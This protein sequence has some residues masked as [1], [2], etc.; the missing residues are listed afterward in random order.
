LICLVVCLVGWAL[1]ARASAGVR[2][3]FLTRVFAQPALCPICNF[4]I[5]QEPVRTIQLDNIVRRLVIR[6]V[7]APGQA[8]LAL[9]LRLT[10]AR[11]LATSACFRT[12]THGMHT[13][14]RI[15]ASML[16]PAV[17]TSAR[18]QT[19]QCEC[20]GV[21]ADR[22]KVCANVFSPL[23]VLCCASCRSAEQR[24]SLQ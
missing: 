12:R 14:N 15:H 1:F 16:G 10:S 9:R 17:A 19:S 20:I 13:V 7:L 3:R 2:A 23:L 5:T 11:G 18:P 4:E 22:H 6:R 24:A 8:T 21:W